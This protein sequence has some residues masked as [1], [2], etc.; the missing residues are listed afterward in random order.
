MGGTPLS[1]AKP[2]AVL[3]HVPYEGPG[4]IATEARARGLRFR[5]VHVYGRDPLPE[6]RELGGLVVMGGPMGVNDHQKHPTLT[7]ELEL[8][9]SALDRDL[10]VLGVCLGAQLLAAALGAPVYRGQHDELGLGQIRLTRAASVDPVLG[11]G[12]RTLPVFHWHR[13]TFDLPAGTVRLAESDLYRN[14]A[15][16]F[17][18]CAYGL[19]FHLELDTALATQ[20]QPH[21]PPGLTVDQRTAHTVGAF[22]C[23]VIGRFFDQALGE[24]RPARQGLPWS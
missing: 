17:G 9:A 10:P 15:F 3:Q 12:Q 2:W 7:A 23:R 4:L 20:W 21:L 19:Q 1:T 6:I 24:S 5:P 22:G 16:R 13:D 18:R 14:Q 8:I 11:L